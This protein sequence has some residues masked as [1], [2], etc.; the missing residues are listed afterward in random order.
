MQSEDYERKARK[1]IPGGVNS[2][3]RLAAPT[4]CFSHARGSK[5][6]DLDG[7]EYIDYAL[8][9]GPTILGHAP[10]SV[11]QAVQETLSLG[12]L[13]AGQH[14]L[15]LEL[16]ELLAAHIPSAERVRIGL[17]GSEMVQA[18]LRVARAHTGRPGFIKFE[19]QYHGWFDNVL[20][21]HSGPANDPAGELPF[22]I[23]LQT[24]GQAVSATTDTHV[25][26][27]ND[28]GA[29]AR[30]LAARGDQI[31]A[32][33]TEPVMCN[34]GALAP[35]DG[36]LQGLRELCDQY[37]VVLIFDEVI[38]GFR[39]GLSGA[40]GKFGV[41]PD[42]STFAKAF[43]GG[44]PV[45]ALAGKAEIMDLFGAG[46]VNHSGTYNS[47]L[48]SIA[49]GIATLRELTADD[50]ALFS[51]IAATGEDIMSG[52]RDAARRH[53]A[54][55]KVLGFGAVFHTLFTDAPETYDYASYKRADAARQKRFMD[56]L[57]P[58][59]IRP[60]G[61]GTWFV[62]AAHSG[63]DVDRTVAAVDQV[64]RAG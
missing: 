24:A 9:M 6:Y 1:F 54:N 15:E 37:G 53:G 14:P 3:V 56:A 25:L 7:N 12:Q 17:T 55:L 5:L 27:W 57:L 20:V 18:A 36:Y 34:T 40:Q 38:T 21:N 32:I 45:A 44:F 41:T 19:G 52:I 46:S 10:P 29:V 58:L 26:P 61:R 47:N 4:I 42:L 43:G 30:L 50:G 49:A 8:G 35:R 28:L 60:T 51:K 63:E 2:N 16:A 31:A 22:P 23:H 11:I 62:S 59:G 39:L 33:I 48:V 64:L 13:F